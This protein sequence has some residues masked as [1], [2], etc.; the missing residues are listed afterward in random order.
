MSKLFE[1]LI[2]ARGVTSEFLRPKYDVLE[3]PYLLPD[4]E[5]AVERI[6]KAVERREKVLI[7]GDYDVDGITASVVMEETLRLIGVENIEIMLP[8]RF[9][10]GY[11]MSSKVITRA[12]K[13]GVELV[14][15]RL[16]FGEQK[17]CSKVE[18][19]ESRCDNYRPS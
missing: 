2:R 11:G 4:M 18:R 8:D 7:Y 3:E 10:D 6:C 13:Q 1:R 14:I 9:A 19:R 17:Y 5:L 12:L 15:S 16:W